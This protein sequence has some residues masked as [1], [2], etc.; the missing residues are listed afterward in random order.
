MFWRKHG[1]VD[2]IQSCHK[3]CHPRFVLQI[4][5]HSPWSNL[6]AGCFFVDVDGIFVWCLA[7]I[8]KSMFWRAA[9]NLSKIH[10]GAR[11]RAFLR[12]FVQPSRTA[13][14]QNKNWD[15]KI[16]KKRPEKSE[17][18][19]EKSEKGPEKGPEKSAADVFFLYTILYLDAL[20]T[21]TRVLMISKRAGATPGC[22]K[23]RGLCLGALQGATNTVLY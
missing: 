11:Q 18:S 22:G 10:A 20:G 21:L 15:F 12:C 8:L 17:R 5:S 23:L 19:P 2:L 9:Q 4:L 16:K 7:F 3:L 13:T 1:H 6:G 14:S